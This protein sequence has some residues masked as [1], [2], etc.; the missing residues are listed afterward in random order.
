LSHKIVE[1]AEAETVDSVES[2]MEAGVKARW[3]HSAGVEGHITA[4]RI[5]L[6]PRKPRRGLRVG[7]RRECQTRD[8][9]SLASS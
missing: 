9:R 4:E 6:E 1:S 8:N 5:A 2:S 3:P 7:Y